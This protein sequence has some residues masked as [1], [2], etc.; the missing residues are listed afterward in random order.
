MFFKTQPSYNINDP[1]YDVTKNTS[2]SL[3]D[4]I[5]SDICLNARTSL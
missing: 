4:I 5:A 2:I 1:L 3:A